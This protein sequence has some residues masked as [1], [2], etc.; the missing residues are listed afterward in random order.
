[1]SFNNIKLFLTFDFRLLTF[2]FRLSTFDSYLKEFGMTRLQK[3]RDGFCHLNLDGMLIS[4]P[5]NRQYLSGF[6]GSTGVLLISASQAVILTDFRYWEQVKYEVKDFEMVKQGPNPWR[7]I[8]DFIMKSHWR[9][10]GFEAGGV[11]Y[12]EYQML[13][14]AALP[15]LEFQPIND[16]VEQIRWVKDFTEIE[17][18]AKAAQITDSAWKNSLHLIKPGVKE[19]EIALEFDYQL[20]LN[21]ADGSAFTTIVASG[22]RS[23]LPHGV[24]STKEILPGDLIIIDGGALYKG[25]HADMTRTVVLGKANPEQLK[26]YNI[27]LKAQQEALD[28]LKSGLT[29]TTVDKVARDIIGQRGYGE[30]FGHG[31][32]HSV[33]LNIHE[34]PRLSQSESSKIPAGAALTVEPGIY[35]PEWGGVRIE[36]LVIVENDSCRNLT[37]SP[38][39]DLI[40]L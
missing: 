30:Y 33:G 20:R 27:V 11:T 32:G 2:D 34:R 24:A 8:I 4:H 6:T 16:L 5:E 31:L 10:V 19:Q 22:R 29:G 21:G 39:N 40:E 3:I 17:L 38:K 13:H 15:G 37:G 23:A 7:S 26:I 9:R 36:D 35:I 1:M 25:Y 12:H 14:D 18:L 28:Y